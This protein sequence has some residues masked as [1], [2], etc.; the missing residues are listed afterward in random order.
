MPGGHAQSALRAFGQM[1]CTL[2]ARSASGGPRRSPARIPLTHTHAGQGGYHHRVP[3]NTK[4]CDTRSALR[5]TAPQVANFSRSPFWLPA[6][7][8]GVLASCSTQR[9]AAA[10]AVA[11][12]SSSGGGSGSPFVLAAAGADASL[13]GLI[14]QQVAVAGGIDAPASAATAAAVAEASIVDGSSGV[15]EMAAAVT[16]MDPAARLQAGLL[17]CSTVDTIGISAAGWPSVQGSGQVGGSAGLGVG[18]VASG[19]RWLGVPPSRLALH[20][21]V[22]ASAYGD[23]TI[24]SADDVAA[25]AA[26]GVALPQYGS[27]S[28]LANDEPID[29]T[30]MLVN[31]AG[32]LAAGA[33]VHACIGSMHKMPG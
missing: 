27:M 16:R 3:I 2:T 13:A 4:H 19:W 12:S 29:V 21:V 30:V 11:G 26:H 24:G 5:C 9:V 7:P 31:T 33:C 8:A 28:T 23:E 22:P 17:A 15:T 25:M 6:V 18:G 20:S 10:S 14:Q 32:G 1:H